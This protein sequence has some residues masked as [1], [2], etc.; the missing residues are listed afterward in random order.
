MGEFIQNIFT[1][2]TV[3][4]SGLLVLVVLYWLIAILGVVEIDSLDSEWDLDSD[5]NVSFVATWLTKFR[6]DGIPLTITLSFI[7]LVAWILCFLS[8]HFIYPMLPVGWIQIIMGFWVLVIAPV[9]AALAVSPFLQPLK[10]LFKKEPVQ[11]ADSLLGQIVRVRSSVVNATFGE[12]E[13][14]D[15]GAG[16]ILKIRAS[17]PNSFTRGDRVILQEY[18]VDSN[19]Y[20]VV[21]AR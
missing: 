21:A 14:K 5:T 12:A 15:G 7:I 10:P 3:F 2:P 11:N 8:V 6:L 9:I 18:D 17:E 20:R 16:L 19:T 4:Y 13:Y 1:F